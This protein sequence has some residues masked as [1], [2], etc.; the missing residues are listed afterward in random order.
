[1][2]KLPLALFALAV[3][4]LAAFA[5]DD[6]ACKHSAPRNLS[7][8]VGNA[9]TVV[10]QIGQHDVRV[11]GAPGKGGRLQGRACASGPGLLDDLT[12]TQERD[13]DR[14]IV[15]AQRK[16]RTVFSL[17][18]HYA[19]LKLEGTVPDN[20][21]VEFDVGSGDAVVRGVSSL[22][23]EVG[24]GDAEARQVKGAVSAKVGSGDIALAD[25]GALE[26]SSIGSGDLE[27]RQVRGAAKVG[28][29]GSGDLELHDVAGDVEIG[30][31]GSG[32]ADLAKVGGSV[33]LGSIGSGDIDID[34]VRGD[35]VV[36]SK[37]SGSVGHANVGG[38]VDV[39][40]KR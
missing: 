27:A 40:K 5:Q 14:L 3:L 39:P 38:K 23:L 28:S 32:D 33:E 20:V 31:I 11:A 7:F 35:L 13:G 1:M 24:S 18:N 21:A 36:R 30:S 37:G 12:L 6:R 29:I 8:E 16:D 4:P 34:G 15:R 25:I 26:V 2:R 9:R 10:F 17:G 22:A 19:Y